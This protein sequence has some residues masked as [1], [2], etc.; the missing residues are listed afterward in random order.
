MAKKT[1]K[2]TAAPK[3]AKKKPAAKTK[4]AAK[5]KLRLGLMTG[6]GDCPGLNAVIRGVVT[7]AEQDGHEVIGFL[8]GWAGLLPPDFK[9]KSVKVPTGQT[10][11]L[12]HADV[13]EI[14]DQGGTI[15]FSSRTNLKKIP[16]GYELAKQ[17]LKKHGIDVLLATGGDDTLSVAQELH[18]EGVHVIGI[19]KT[20]D[21]DLPGTDQTFGFDTAANIAMDA[22]DK[23]HSTAK[24]HERCLV[25]EIM[26][27]HAGWIT[28]AAGVAAHAHVVLIP[29]VP[30]D[31]EDI[32]RVV[33]D[34][35]RAGKHYTIVACS[36]GARPLKSQIDAMTD[37]GDKLEYDAFG[38]V[39]LGGVGGKLADLI[40]RNTG[41]ETRDVLLGHL[42]RGGAPT[43][44]DRIFGMRL[45]VAAVECAIRGQSGKFLSLQGTEIRPIDITEAL[46]SSQETRKTKNVS[47]EHY[48][49]FRSFFG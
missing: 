49:S 4:P 28:L 18:R 44:F 34:R 47:L 22:I 27:R 2:K 32:Y 23:L 36:E 26:G 33:R 19:P 41:V 24:S 40:E 35:K 1:V 6:G 31:L 46:G 37:P 42:Q 43:M 45:G 3:P 16:G 30:F 7:R 48:E 15:L 14:H 5:R 29:E 10:L 13:E 17:T 8:R 39:K 11:R 9:D 25:V 20:I 21:N 38:N 12:T